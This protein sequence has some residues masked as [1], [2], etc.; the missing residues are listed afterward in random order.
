MDTPHFV[1]KE[2]KREIMSTDIFVRI[3][4]DEHAGTSLQDDLEHCFDMFRA[5]EARFSRFKKDSELSESN[6]YLAKTHP[7]SEEFLAL[8]TKSVEYHIFT[9]GLFNPTILSALEK[10]A[11]TK[12]LHA[13]SA[14][15]DDAEVVDSPILSLSNIEINQASHEIYTHG[16]RLDFGGIGKGYIIDQVT[17]F[18][19]GQGYRNFLVDA[20]GDL[21]ASGKNTEKHYDHWAIGI[22]HPEDPHQSVGTLVLSDRAA[23]T[24]G[25]NRRHW[26]NGA[27][28]KHHIIDPRTG[29]STETDLVC[30][31][32]VAYE[33]ALAD[34]LA[35][36][37]LILGSTAGT[38]FANRKDIAAL[39][40]HTDGTT[41]MTPQLNS[42]LWKE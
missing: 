36:S 42:Y 4:S 29:K 10:E 41:T 23:T 24:S 15:A 27:E 11:Y 2:V 8:L 32:V 33:T 38:K 6:R 31:T 39:L 12:S 13:E 37:I 17:G 40:V 14:D 16:A 19:R 9:E 22:E 30:V 20:G 35:K 21:Y 18:L 28:V 5:F 25:I 34:V 1:E 7:V 3:E 26:I